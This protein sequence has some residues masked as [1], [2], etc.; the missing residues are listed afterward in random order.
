[1][2][3]IV[4]LI[5]VLALALC[6]PCAAL[7]QAPSAPCRIKAEFPHAPNTFTQGLFI[8]NGR[9]Y[10]SSGGYGVSFVAEV[11]L[12]TGKHLKRRDVEPRLFAEGMAPSGGTVRLLTWRSGTGLLLALDDLAPQ[13]T[14]DYRVPT[15]HTEGWGLTCDG[16]RFILSSGSDMLHFHQAEDFSPTGGV[17][18]HDGNRAVRQLNELEYVEGLVLANIWKR[19]EIAVIDPSDGTVTARIDLAPLRAR[20]APNSG[21]AN[22]IAY[23]RETGRLFVTGKNWDKLFEIEPDLDAWQRPARDRE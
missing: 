16:N 8:E 15:E 10:E 14:F 20:I 17:R 22:G 5:A 19:D 7:A 6:L 4:R 13:G 1:M 2:S 23:D 12:Q 18:V 3:R 21:V 11:D 9:L